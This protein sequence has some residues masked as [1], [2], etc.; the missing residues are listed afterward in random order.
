MSPKARRAL[1]ALLGALLMC[2]VVYGLV[3][4]EAGRFGVRWFWNCLI[5]GGDLAWVLVTQTFWLLV[6]AV[7][8]GGI[9]GYWAAGR[10]GKSSDGKSK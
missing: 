4:D 8:A 10:I 1:G 7:I 2:A 9:G 5:H 3:L 6:V